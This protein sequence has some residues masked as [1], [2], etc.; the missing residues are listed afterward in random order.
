VV[1]GEGQPWEQIVDLR[2]EDHPEPLQELRRLVVLHD[3]YVLAGEGDELSGKG[4]HNGAAAKYV[5]AYERAPHAIELEFWAGLS[6]VE[7][8]ETERGLT[9]LRSTIE[10]DRGWRELLDRLEPASSPAAVEARRL[11]DA[12]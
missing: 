12:G 9:H 10:R 3:A 1:P 5:A 6:L 2:V 11:L 4:D 7:T 8:G